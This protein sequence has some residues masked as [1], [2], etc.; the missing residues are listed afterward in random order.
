[1]VNTFIVVP[2]PYTNAKYLDRNRLNSQRREA[3]MIIDVLEKIDYAV[4]N[5]LPLDYSLLP[6]GN[7][8]A[9][10][11]WVGYTNPLKVYYNC[12]VKRWIEL[13]YENNMPLYEIDENQYHVVPCYFDG[14]RTYFNGVFDQYAFP[15]WFSFPPFYMSHRAA[16][17]LKDPVFYSNLYT[18]DLKP[19]LTRGYLWPK[20]NGLEIYINWNLNYLEELGTGI[21][22]KYRYSV[23]DTKRW[24]CSPFVNPKT[25]RSIKENGTIYREYKEAAIGHGLIK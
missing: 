2:D 15:P 3:K 20:N 5:G 9:T 13:G 10:K 23:E 1:M 6:W 16:L 17:F 11:M 21:P 12:I 4:A 25:G 8:P 22:A 18:E 14:V 7:H 19:Y 24:L